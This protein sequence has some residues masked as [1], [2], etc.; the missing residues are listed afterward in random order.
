[1]AR[2][3]NVATLFERVKHPASLSPY[4]TPAAMLDAVKSRRKALMS[5]SV[6]VSSLVEGDKSLGRLL[7][8]AFERTTRCMRQ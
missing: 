5:E 3:F 6:W 4:K 1:M 8:M 2:K 7:N